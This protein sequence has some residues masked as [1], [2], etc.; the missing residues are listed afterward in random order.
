M[1]DP[2][3]REVDER[4][5][6]GDTGYALLTEL[7][8]LIFNG[9]SGG[10]P[11]L[12]ARFR[13]RGLGDVFD[14]WVGNASRKRIDP[15]QLESVFGSGTLSTMADRLGIAR[16]TAAA[17]ACVLLP[18]LIALLTRSGNLPTSLP[19]DFSRYLGRR[20]PDDIGALDKPPLRARE[21]EP[22][23]NLAP[24]LGWVKWALLATCLIGLAYS[25]LHRRHDPEN[26]SAPVVRPAAGAVSATKS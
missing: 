26:A 8:T 25:L 16:A 9:R 3:I 14:S 4:F 13:Q 1:L 6:L 15:L 21:A 20:H 10:V 23:I 22:E 2:L 11:G 12:M 24:G 17:A 18:R 5:A 19:G 7:L